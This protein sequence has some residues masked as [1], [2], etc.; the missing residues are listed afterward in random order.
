MS[1]FPYDI[2]LFDL[3]GT[4]VES[5]HDLADAVNHALALEGR[6]PVTPDDLRQKIGGGAVGML[7]RALEAQGGMVDRDRFEILKEALLDHYWAHIADKTVPFPGCIAAL[8][9]LIERGC[10]LAVCTNKT[11]GPARILLKALGMDHLFKTVYG[12]DTLGKERAKPQPD[13]LLAAVEDCGGGRFAMIGDSTYDT[14]AGRAAGATVVAV[15][16]GY[17]D[18]PAGELDCDALIDHFDE[19]VPA[20]AALR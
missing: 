4:L 8:E 15:S 10:T 16:F 17:N 2:V 3:D 9:V 5:H 13:M 20:L 6:A 18:R 14:S 11:E 12:S 19:L 7:K 1:E